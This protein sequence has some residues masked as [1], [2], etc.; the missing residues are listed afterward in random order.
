V[1]VPRR[2]LRDPVVGIVAGQ[3]RFMLAVRAFG[4]SHP[5]RIS[6]DRQSAI[7]AARA[8]NVT[9]SST[10]AGS[11]VYRTRDLTSSSRLSIS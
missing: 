11:R 8:I 3:S 10:I 7:A 4:R 6:R 5:A 1:D 2:D 9:I